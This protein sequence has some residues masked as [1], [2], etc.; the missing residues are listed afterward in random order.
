MNDKTWTT[1]EG[2][3]L[4]ITE[5]ATPHLL[6][7]LHMIERNR[8]NNILSLVPRIEIDVETFDYYSQWPDG[9]FDL[10]DEC[11]RRGLVGRIVVEEKDIR[12]KRLKRK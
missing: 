4:K 6:S 10:L 11:V 7:A 9:Y 2:A 3:I 12:V 1:K 8:M 5:M